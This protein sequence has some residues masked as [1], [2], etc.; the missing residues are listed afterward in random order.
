MVVAIVV[1]HEVVADFHLSTHTDVDALH[2]F[3]GIEVEPE[4][5][6]RQ[7]NQLATD[8]LVVPYIQEAREGAESLCKGVA[9]N[10]SRL[11]S[12]ESLK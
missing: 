1:E 5:R 8:I 9:P 3:Q 2:A 12:V 7:Q 6:L 10:G 4:L 11:E